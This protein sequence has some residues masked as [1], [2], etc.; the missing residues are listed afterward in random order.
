MDPALPVEEALT[1]CDRQDTVV[2]DTGVDVQTP[3]T[4]TPKRDHLLR[5]E[6]IPRYA[7]GT[8]KG[9]LSLGKNS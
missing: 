3:A 4:I 8:T 2:P 6:V 1:V 5:G 7:T 9:L